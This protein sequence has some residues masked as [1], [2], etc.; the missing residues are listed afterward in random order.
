M[1][2]FEEMVVISQM[3]MGAWVPTSGEAIY[4]SLAS[5]GYLLMLTTTVVKRVK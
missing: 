4:R 5:K 2:T 3:Q 1:L